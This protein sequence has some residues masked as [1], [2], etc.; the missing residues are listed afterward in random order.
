MM[1]KNQQN[2]QEMTEQ[3]RA[4]LANEA[5]KQGCVSCDDRYCGHC[6]YYDGNGYCSDGTPVSPHHWCS[7]FR[8][9]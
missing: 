7:H 2:R 3:Q 9:A 4:A 8:Y 1:E 6:R 5:V